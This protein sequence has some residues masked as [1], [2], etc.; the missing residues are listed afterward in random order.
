V[1]IG[2]IFISISASVNEQTA[3]VVSNKKPDQGPVCRK[4]TRDSVQVHFKSV[5]LYTLASNVYMSFFACLASVIV[6]IRFG[7]WRL[8]AKH[9]AVQP[10]SLMCPAEA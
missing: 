4:M 10:V 2:D 5:C 1:Y 3:R 9:R 7:I 6:R 8:V